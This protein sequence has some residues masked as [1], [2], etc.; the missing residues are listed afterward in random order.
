[1]QFSMQLT[2]SKR[3]SKKNR[4]HMKLLLMPEYFPDTNIELIQNTFF[5]D[6]EN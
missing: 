5:M 2:I 6:V 3:V 4:G 1:M